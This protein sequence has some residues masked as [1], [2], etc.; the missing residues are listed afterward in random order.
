[1]RRFQ[2]GNLFRNQVTVSGNQQR[3][4]NLVRIGV[5]EPGE[6][7][8]GRVVGKSSLTSGHLLENVIDDG[9]L[10]QDDRA[11]VNLASKAT[12]G[13]QVDQQLGRP[14]IND[15]LSRSRRCDFPPPTVK[16]QHRLYPFTHLQV[17]NKPLAK[18]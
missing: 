9:T 16:E 12:A 15:I 2:V 4:V 13:A 1:V 7:Y 10:Y 17:N 14:V 18:G 3:A 8:I 5:A 6:V 11:L